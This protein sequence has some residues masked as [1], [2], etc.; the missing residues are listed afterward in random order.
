[1]YI[2]KYINFPACPRNE[3][4]TL[5]Y[6]CYS[7][8]HT[9]KFPGM[10]VSSLRV[11]SSD[12][13]LLCNICQ[14]F[15]PLLIERQVWY[16]SLHY[17]Q[18]THNMLLTIM[19]ISGSGT[20]DIVSVKVHDGQLQSYYSS[21]LVLLPCLLVHWLLVIIF[22][23]QSNNMQKCQSINGGINCILFPCRSMMK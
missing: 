19:A 9:T 8:D 7:S 3:F 22:Y 23:I 16:S 17:S 18:Q 10:P 6:Y 5:Q 2:F 14:Q 20:C 4:T 21:V 15:L 13:V 12:V 1:M 11:Y